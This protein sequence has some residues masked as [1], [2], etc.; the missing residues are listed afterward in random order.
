MSR[1]RGP[2]SK[3]MSS[4]P[5]AS[6]ATIEGRQWATSFRATTT[7]MGS[8]IS[9]LAL[10]RGQD[11]A[12]GRNE[13]VLG[14]RFADAPA[15]RR[16]EG[17]G[18]AAADDQGVDLR[19]Q[20]PSR[21][22]LVEIFAPPTIAITGCAGARR[23]LQ[24]LELGL[25]GAS[26][27]GGQG[28]AARSRCQ[29]VFAVRDREGIVDAKIAE[30][31]RACGEILIVVLLALVEAGVL[32][33]EN[34]AILHPATAASASGPRV[35]RKSDRPFEDLR[36]CGRNGFQRI[37]RVQP[38]RPAEMRQQDHLA[39]LVG[40]LGDG[41]GDRSIRVTSPTMPS[42]IGTLRSTRSKHPFALDVGIIEAAKRDHGR[43]GAKLAK[44]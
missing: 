29:C 16:K 1:L 35:L 42:S 22:S 19:E 38:L 24:G 7:S 25:H 21:S 37:L 31:S 43:Q 30:R 17:V 14:E 6:T 2:R 41:R 28:D 18:H 20:M 13:I 8:R 23:L 9:R 11:I 3:I 15:L 44:R 33:A 36:H 27:V 39:A 40:E 32:Q 5:T 26:G 12:G 4:S 10:G 34:I